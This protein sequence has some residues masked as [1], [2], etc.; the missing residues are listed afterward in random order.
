MA[1]V[2]YALRENTCVY[3]IQVESFF[4]DLYKCYILVYYFYKWHAYMYEGLIIDN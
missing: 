3:K 4:K 2:I 1:I